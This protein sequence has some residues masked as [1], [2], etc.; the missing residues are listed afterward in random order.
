MN[1]GIALTD[2][3]A[4]DIPTVARK[5]EEYGFDS[6]WTPEHLVYPVRE[7]DA[8]L[9]PGGFPD[10]AKMMDPFMVL[11]AAA[12][13]TDRIM[14]GTGVCLVPQR[15]PLLTAKMVSSLDVLSKGRFLF[16][17][18]AGWLEPEARIFGADF[19]HRWAQTRDFVL[20]MK[21]WWSNDRASYRGSHANFEEVWRYPQPVQSP[22]PPILIAGVREKVTERIVD[23]GDGWIPMAGSIEPK[24]LETGRKNIE[25]ALRDAGRDTS[26]FTVTVYSAKPDRERNRD[27]ADAGA[28]RIVH[29]VSGG[30]TERTLDSMERI[31]E[32]IP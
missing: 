24:D 19:P 10:M 4:V 28:D 22:H 18:G 16:G 21:A 13:V 1:L 32:L 30:K 25:Q 31:A 29:F 14:L 26:K 11:S 5:A 7:E 9:P 23:Y 6:L 12:A 17:I 27:Y 20:A 3:A 8:G 2:T 15:H